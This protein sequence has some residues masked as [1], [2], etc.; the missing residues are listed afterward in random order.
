MARFSLNRLRRDP[1]FF[2]RFPD[3][4]FDDDI[5]IETPADFADINRYSLELEC[6][7]PRDHLQSCDARERVDDFFA[8]AVAKVAL[9]RFWTHVDERQYGHGRSRLEC[10]A[11]F[12]A[13]ALWLWVQ[14]AKNGHV[15]A[16]PIDDV[17]EEP[18]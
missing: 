8:D 6:R 9:L 12:L 7:R 18:A 16:G 13:R 11:D 14:P 4:S 5:G 17:R 15:T 3:A 2:A 10:S 1:Q